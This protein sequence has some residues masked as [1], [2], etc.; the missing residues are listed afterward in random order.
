M[1]KKSGALSP[2]VASLFTCSS[3]LFV[4]ESI[5]QVDKLHRTVC[6]CDNV[7]FT[8][9]Y[10]VTQRFYNRKCSQSIRRTLLLLL[11]CFPCIKLSQ[12]AYYAHRPLQLSSFRSAEFQTKNKPDNA[13]TEETNIWY[14]RFTERTTAAPPSSP[15]INYHE[16]S[17][18]TR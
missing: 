6:D 16:I 10:G 2:S 18:S 15:A 17:I 9:N 4:V 3:V 14:T 13:V 5:V 1:L 12:Y 7:L 11:V 8:D